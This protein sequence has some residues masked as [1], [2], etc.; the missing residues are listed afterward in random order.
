M[1]D[2]DFLYVAGYVAGVRM[3]IILC[4]DLCKDGIPVYFDAGDGYWWHRDLEDSTID[5]LCS[6]SDVH[7]LVARLREGK[8][9]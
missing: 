1:A 7:Q 9:A 6:A 3:A 8:T 4:C 5:H 2:L